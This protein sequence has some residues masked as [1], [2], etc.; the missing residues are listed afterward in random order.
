[1]KKI[2]SPGLKTLKAKMLATV[3]AGV[4]VLFIVILLNNSYSMNLIE[5]RLEKTLENM[6]ALSNEYIE[7]RTNKSRNIAGEI[8]VNPEVVTLASPYIAESDS[9]KS[10]SEI[11]DS[12]LGLVS[13]LSGANEEIDSIYLYYES[14]K[15]LI[16]SDNST[17]KTNDPEAVA[18]A[19]VN[20]GWDMSGLWKDYYSEMEGRSYISMMYRLDYLNQEIRTPVYLAVNFDKRA[21]FDFLA[22]IKLTENASTA[23]VSFDDN[24]YM[25]EANFETVVDL[26]TKLRGKADELEKGLNIKLNIQGMGKCIIKY[27]PLES[28]KGGRRKFARCR[29]WHT[30]GSAGC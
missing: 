9:Y 2:F 11:K 14:R 4:V 6:S 8:A 7:L 26:K 23:L 30:P 21:M 22:K 19:H 24:V 10:L 25:L 17:S 27:L 18:W 5:D 3:S 13:Y 20:T 28:G 29:F 15:T 1:M 16:N 12:V